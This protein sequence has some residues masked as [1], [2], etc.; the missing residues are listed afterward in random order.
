V[1][2]GLG[3][4]REQV[5]RYRLQVQQV[6]RRAGDLAGTA[7]LDLGVQDTGPDGAL[8]ALALRGVGVTA[9]DQPALARQLATVW[10]LR[11]APH[12]YRRGDLPSVAAAVAP[13]SDRDAGARIVDASKPLATA[14]IGNL[15]ALDTVAAAMRSV[16]TEPMVK[17]DVSTA[18]TELLDPPYVRYCRRCGATHAYEQPFRLGALRAGLELQPGTSPPVLEPIPGFAPADAPSP[19]HDVVR[20]YLHLLG[21]ATPRLVAGYLDAPVADVSAR[22]PDDA[23]EVS[24]AGAR[25]WL[26]ADDAPAL[27]A[28]RRPGGRSRPAAVLLGP[29]DLVLQAR[30]RELLV[31]DRA[32]AKQLWPVLGRPGAVLYDGEIAGTWRPR[33]SGARL[34][35]AVTDWTG[36]TPQPAL[37]AAAEQLARFRGVGLAGVDAT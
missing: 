11:G 28:A 29:Y 8:W 14:G 19:R 10:S 27:E 37:V 12:V 15:D 20:G 24:V 33:Q 36:T 17:G 22:W 3:A 31:P 30:D 5:L 35:V 2:A 16:V 21:P 1:T 26:L 4:D 34:R 18:V 9:A 7:V 23:V 13:F 32:R 6:G 25:R